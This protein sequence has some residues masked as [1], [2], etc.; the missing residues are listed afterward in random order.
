MKFW[1]ILC[2]L[3]FQDCRVLL[4]EAP[5][6]SWEGMLKWDSAFSEAGHHS[7]GISAP[8]NFTSEQSH[9][10]GWEQT[11]GTADSQGIAEKQDWLYFQSLVP[12]VGYY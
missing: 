9:V 10:V 1:E 8:A 4:R 12:Y 2:F 7:V 3:V 5:E 6:L 11:G